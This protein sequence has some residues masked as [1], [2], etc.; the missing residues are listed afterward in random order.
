MINRITKGFA[1]C[2]FPDD[3]KKLFNIALANGYLMTCNDLEYVW[4]SFSSTRG[5]SWSHTDNWCDSDLL[6]IIE[7]KFD[8]LEDQ[9]LNGV[10]ND[11]Q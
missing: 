11:N 3:V 5:E 7:S 2:R 1:D 4:E 6:T 8:E 10:L 9:Q